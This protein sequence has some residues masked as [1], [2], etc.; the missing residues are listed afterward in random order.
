MLEHFFEGPLEG[1]ER[2]NPQHSTVSRK[3]WSQG[4]GINPRLTLT[5]LSEYIAVQLI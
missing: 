2:T 5:L 3:T 4:K 1:K